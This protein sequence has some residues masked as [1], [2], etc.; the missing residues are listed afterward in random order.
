MTGEATVVKNAGSHFLLSELPQ[1]APFPAVLRGKV[2]LER[3]GATNPVAVG[4]RVRYALE[5]T[6]ADELH[7]AVIQ[8]YL[9]DHYPIIAVIA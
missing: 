3:S 1:W 7:P 2:R 4:D 8:E 9:S 6:A 5:G